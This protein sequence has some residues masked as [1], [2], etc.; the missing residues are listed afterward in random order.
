MA[1]NIVSQRVSGNS[2]SL[3][4]TPTISTSVYAAGDQIGGIMELDPDLVNCE[5]N[6]AFVIQSISFIDKASQDAAID[7]LFFSESV[8]LASDNA[9]ADVSDADLVSYYLGH[10]SIAATDYSALNDNS[11]GSVRNVGLQLKMPTGGGDAK[12]YVAAVSRGTPT[13]ASTSDLVFKFHLA[14]DV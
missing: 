6:D 3:T 13:Y 12:I 8:T 4:A 5:P 2:F 14:G 9:A 11:V 10:V 7:L 1:L